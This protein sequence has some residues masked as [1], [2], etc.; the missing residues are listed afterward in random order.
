MC[1]IGIRPTFG[2]KRPRLEV[3]ILDDFSRELYGESLEVHFLKFIR[4]ERAF[5][6]PSALIEQI[7]HDVEEVKAYF[8]EEY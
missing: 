2:G 7:S 6:G 8:I 3:H 5:D 1:N 4:E